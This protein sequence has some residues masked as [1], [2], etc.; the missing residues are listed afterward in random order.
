MQLYDFFQ[1][2]ILIRT[3]TILGFEVNP[4]RHGQSFENGVLI[5]RSDSFQWPMRVSNL[6]HWNTFLQSRLIFQISHM[7]RQGT[8]SFLSKSVLAI[9]NRDPNRKDRVSTKY[10]IKKSRKSCIQNLTG[11]L[12]YL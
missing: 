5:I 2:Y 1:R 10:I 9:H 11:F 3:F 6:F 7:Y 4:K 8:L 12:F